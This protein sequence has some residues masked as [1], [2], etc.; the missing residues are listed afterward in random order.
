LIAHD[1]TGRGLYNDAT[2]R[3]ICPVEF[4]WDNTEHRDKIRN[5]DQ[6]FLISANSW[7]RFLYQD[8]RYNPQHPSEGLFRV[9]LLVK[10]GSLFTIHMLKTS[11]LPKFPGMPTNFHFAKLR[12]PAAIAYIAVQLRF[13]LSSCGSW[14]PV[15]CLFDHM[16]F[17]N[18]ILQ[19]FEDIIDAEEKQFI[20]DLLMW[21]DIQIFG[22]VA[23][24]NHSEEVASS[25]SVAASFKRWRT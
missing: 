11:L 1:K 7:P 20:D 8:G 24:I 18:N 22:Q 9:N 23:L 19:W 14:R 15:D 2:A 6:A 25:L 5:W 13:A 17:Y 3:M 4:N 10:V 21:W 16:K 12:S